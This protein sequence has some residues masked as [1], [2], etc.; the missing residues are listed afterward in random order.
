MT[1]AG[2]AKKL[3][4]LCR[5]VFDEAG[6]VEGL[7]RL[8]GGANME[9]WAFDYAGRELVLRRMPAGAT[10]A[11]EG[12]GISIE[13]EAEVIQAACRANVSAPD[14]IT[15]LAAGDELGRGFVMTRLPGETL[16]KPIQRGDA[17]APARRVFVAECARELA[18]IHAMDVTGPLTRLPELPSSLATANLRQRYDGFGCQSVVF[19]ATFAWLDENE[20]ESV[21]PCVLHGDFRLGN[22]L[23]KETGLSAVLDWEL[24][25]LGD[26][27]Q[28]LAYICAPAWRFTNHDKP[29]AGLGEIA[30]FLSAYEAAGGE[31]I[32]MQRFRFWLVYST[33]WWGT[34]CL[35][36]ANFWRTGF[37]RSLERAVI[38]RRVSEVELELVM[39]QE[40][41]TPDETAKVCWAEP[42]REQRHNETGDDEL[43]VALTEWISKD[44]LPDA[45]G[46]DK[47][48][49]LVALTGLGMIER[50]NAFGARFEAAQDA[51]RAA[52]GFSRNE[53]LARAARGE[54]DFADAETLRHLRL[55]TLEQLYIDQPK[56]AGFKAALAKWT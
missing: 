40:G 1:D 44:I 22:L 48:Q 7:K 32:S 47:F 3:D 17:Y 42:A 38:G 5:R 34:S 43:A 4:Q 28:D 46:R 16:A 19:E 36:M 39:L 56:Y 29:V 12:M 2:F 23:V 35:L 25:H 30:E 31:K 11:E 26:P 13:T 52:L 50:S 18:A 27:A 54:I 14:V 20:P 55:S 24:A 51:R 9:T 41:V 8:T 53:M 33:L 15:I 21:A 45:T 6:E 49:G 37:D 10:D